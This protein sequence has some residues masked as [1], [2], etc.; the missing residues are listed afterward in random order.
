MWE[1]DWDELQKT[2]ELSDEELF[3]FKEI[4][5]MV[6]I[7]HITYLGRR[8]FVDLLDMLMIEVTEDVM[9]KMFQEMDENHDGQI[10][11]EEFITAMVN[12]IGKE[13]LAQVE[14]IKMGAC[15]TRMW[16]R[17]EIAWSANTGLIVITGCLGL[18]AL[19]YFQ[20]FL[21]P[22]VTAYLF[23]FF[24]T[25][26]MNFFVSAA[27]PFASS[28]VASKEA[29]GQ[30]HRPIKVP[31]QEIYCCDLTTENPDGEVDPKTGEKERMY[32]SEFRRSLIGK[33][34][35]GEF[36]D[37]VTS[38]KVPQG[39]AM[40]LTLATFFGVLYGLLALVMA[41]TSKL[42]EDQVFIDR[43]NNFTDEMF[44]SLKKNGYEIKREETEGY[45]W[46]EI[47]NSAT[48]LNGFVGQ[49]G[50]VFLLL[51]Y[52]LSEKSERLLFGDGGSEG[53]GMLQEIEAQVTNYVALKT[54]LSAMTGIIVGLILWALGVKLAA[55]WGILSFVLNFIPNV[56]SMIAMFLPMPI[57]I[58][59]PNLEDWQK[60]LAFLGPALVQLIVGNVW[61]PMV[62]GKSLNL[63][64]ISILMAL[65]FWTSVWGLMGAIL[66]VPLL[67]I[68]K[69]SLTHANHPLAKY[70]LTLIREDPTV[71]E[72]AEASK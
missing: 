8:N 69:I 12:N 62:F 37:C 22:L 61:E 60:V 17:G 71:D 51:I 26:I 52:I 43:I 38:G 9:E 4:F 39:L 66:S 64:A 15:G 3:K 5:S 47:S 45:T 55:I 72:T 34:G 40:L 54:V 46:D 13:Q 57:V 24:L 19:I 33:A 2:L 6:D 59:D 21:F 53:P 36:Y 41:E 58:V 56:G 50:V 14:D 35:Q 25:P 28:F 49:F 31:F 67:A 68:Q 42:Q 7:E 44:D 16:E 1:G 48:A 65:V 63:T 20:G 27:A 18:K 29:A 23:V 30:M 32:K 10:E 11:F 70:F